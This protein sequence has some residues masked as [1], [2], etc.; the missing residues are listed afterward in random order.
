MSA[1]LS[2]IMTT[3]KNLAT[4]I[5][6]IATQWL[7]VQG[8]SVTT[9]ISS[10]TIVKNAAGRICV[11]SVTTAGTTPG[12]AYDANTAGITT[13]PLYIIPN[14]VGV[15]VVNLPTNYGLLVVPGT[16]QVVT[17]SWS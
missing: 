14:T 10:S 2:D 1:S 15:F 4:A 7:G 17:V 11:V 16:G 8:S 3:A 13:R 9:A 12:T 5:N 6:G